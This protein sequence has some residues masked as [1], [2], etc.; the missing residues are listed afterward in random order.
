MDNISVELAKSISSILV[1]TD[2]EKILKVRDFLWDERPR[3]ADEI[4]KSFDEKLLDL[5]DYVYE[6]LWECVEK[7][8]EEVSDEYFIEGMYNLRFEY[9]KTDDDEYCVLICQIERKE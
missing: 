8:Y 9:H 1:T 2:Y 4:E 7:A 3:D 5:K 6:K